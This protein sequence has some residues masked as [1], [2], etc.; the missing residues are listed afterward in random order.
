MDAKQVPVN[1]SPLEPVEGMEEQV[2]AAAMMDFLTSST[3]AERDSEDNE[4]ATLT[5]LAPSPSVL[6]HSSTLPCFP[7]RDLGFFKSGKQEFI[8]L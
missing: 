3:F 1:A 7:K 2:N 5:V 6:V 8:R 4:S